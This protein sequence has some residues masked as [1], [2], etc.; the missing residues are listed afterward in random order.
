MQ[1]GKTPQENMNLDNDTR[2]TML[3]LSLQQQVGDSVL[4][5][6]LVQLDPSLK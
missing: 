4:V 6:A 3:A 5:S 1:V 2:V